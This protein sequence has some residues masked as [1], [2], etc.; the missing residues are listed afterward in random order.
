MTDGSARPDPGRPHPA[1]RAAYAVGL[2]AVIVLAAAMLRSPFVAVAPVAGVIGEDLGVTA[3]V[4]G[5]LTSIPVLCFA[6]FAPLA[7]VVIRRAGADVALTLSLGGSVIGCVVRSLGG[8]EA[9]IVGTAIMGVF[10]TIGNVVIPV[11]IARDFPPRRVHTMT[12]VF[13]SSLNVGTM[14]VTLSTAPLAEIVGWR[15]ALAAWAGFGLAALAV[16]IPLR[17]LRA[18][19]VPAPG[20][21]TAAP[22]EQAP[23][24]RS[25][26]TW[27]LA[28]AFA[29]QA[30][31]FYATTAWL[32]TL[33]A[34]QGLSD[35]AAGAVAA[36]FQVA[37]IAGSMTIPLV[38]MRSSMVVGVAAVAAGWLCIPLGFLFAPG[39]WLVWC[40]VGGV[41]QGGGITSVFI[42]ISGF[43]GDQ[44][45]TAARSGI[46]QGVGYAVAAAGPI[47]LGVMHE[48]SGAWTLPLLVLLGA[49]L[50]FLVCGLLAAPAM[51]RPAASEAA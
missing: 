6:V 47:A 38:T 37:G 4:V 21:A 32:P 22:I 49:V 46:V 3:G 23:V 30:F 16:W 48:A 12:G 42:M 7:I 5:L 27:L 40:I 35:S 41:A 36:I 45:A 34:D 8:I 18:A 15:G 39:L 20:P 33:L 10:L 26:A 9:A 51:R 28:A 31:A 13:T 29:G 19:F 2:T 24:L 50:V 25:R 11:I 43:G 17:G 14:I 1:P 44:R